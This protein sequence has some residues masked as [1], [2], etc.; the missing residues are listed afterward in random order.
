[1]RTFVKALSVAALTSSTW[2]VHAQ[3]SLPTIQHTAPEPVE[4]HFLPSANIGTSFIHVA[5][6][7]PPGLQVVLN[8]YLNKYY[9]GFSIAGGY[10]ESLNLF[11]AHR[12][13]TSNIAINFGYA[14]YKPYYRV[15]V[16]PFAGVS[17]GTMSADEGSIFR[18]TR[19]AATSLL[20]PNVGLRMDVVSHHHIGITVMAQVGLGKFYPATIGIMMRF[21]KSSVYKPRVQPVPIPETDPRLM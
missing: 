15:V 3:D 9:L 6:Q 19:T 8:G 7:T 11:S 4:W 10:G 21:G 17:Q 5:R 14:L 16:T 1:M 13:T 12:T 18:S 20:M 2:S